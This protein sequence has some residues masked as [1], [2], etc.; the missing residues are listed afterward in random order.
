MK[1]LA[2]TL[3]LLALG[4][5]AGM[6]FSVGSAGA[7]QPQTTQ[8][9][10]EQNV[11]ARGNIKVE[12]QGT[13]QVSLTG[14]PRVGLDPTLGNTVKVDPNSNTVQVDQSASGP[15]D[16]RAADNPAFSPV[17][18]AMTLHLPEGHFD[19]QE[20]V[21]SVPA[22]EELVIE[23]ASFL[24]ID[25]AA[26]DSTMA[27]ITVRGGGAGG[28]FVIPTVAEGNGPSLGTPSVGESQ[29]RIYADP[30]TLVLCAIAR[31]DYSTSA[32]S[33]CSISGYLVPVK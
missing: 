6:L 11:D 15:L 23:Q 18:A 17:V 9:V 2:I 4:A 27:D 30:G 20:V 16:T 1:R 10:R 19:D 13:P 22:H 28:L 5:T 14:S 31:T 8:L 33:N 25:L 7:G 26:G 29:T 32:S 3:G 24:T 12:E 21:Y